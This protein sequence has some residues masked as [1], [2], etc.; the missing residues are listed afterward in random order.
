M[1]LD[2]IEDLK[3]N[4]VL[5]AKIMAET[6][7]FLYWKAH[8]DANDVEFVLAPPPLIA[9]RS[10]HSEGHMA[11]HNTINSEV[12]GEHVVWILD[13]DCCRPMSQD[14]KGV[15]Q[16]VTAFHRNDPFYPRPKGDSAMDQAVWTVFKDRFLEASKSILKCGSLEARLPALWVEL[17]ERRES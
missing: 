2:Q 17:V 12:L 1:H 5:Y 14:E 10:V 9:A 3:L 7:A 13:S 16:A 6:L 15:K 11:H 8:I 4:A